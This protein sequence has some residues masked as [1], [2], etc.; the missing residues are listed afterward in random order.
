LSSTSKISFT[1]EN[2]LIKTHSTP[3]QTLLVLASTPTP[4]PY[5]TGTFVPDSTP[6]PTENPVVTITPEA[7]LF[8]DEP[9]GNTAG[10]IAN[11][12][13]F[14]EQ[15]DWIYF[16]NYDDGDGGISK[17]RPDGSDRIF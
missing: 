4:T 13:L 14:A 7:T 3:T 10:N 1:I 16:V 15:D 5:Q 17:M 8:I 9:R 11:S 12:G 6:I 2:T